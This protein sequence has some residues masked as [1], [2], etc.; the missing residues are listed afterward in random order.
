ME[1]EVRGRPPLVPMG[2]LDL[3]QIIGGAFRLLGITTAVT[4]GFPIAA[5]LIEFVVLI[6][7]VVALG[8]DRPQHWVPVAAFLAV[9]GLLWIALLTVSTAAS[10]VVLDHAVRGRRIGAAA[11][12]F[13]GLRRAPGLAGVYLAALV[14]VVVIV[15]VGVLPFYLSAI[16]GSTDGSSL[17]FG[18]LLGLFA[19]CAYGYACYVQVSLVT[20]G[21]AYVVEGIGIGAA[22]S[23]AREQTRG[24]WWRTFAT[25][26]VSYLVVQV[27]TFAAM[28]VVTLVVLLPGQVHGWMVAL[29]WVAVV[30]S[31]AT[32]FLT[33][34]IGLLYYDQR[35]RSR[36]PR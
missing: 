8:P 31:V 26:L 1:I 25:L 30:A 20:A 5:T 35:A 13:A 12:L 23:V 28:L 15:A 16:I 33:G 36:L 10:F 3:G 6:A 22:L 24:N 14:L 2:P 32:P 18:L 17:L 27:I 9:A 19:L 34:V 21:P 29:L 11:A 7:G 4:V